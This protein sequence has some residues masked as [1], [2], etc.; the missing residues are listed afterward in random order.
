[1]GE[2]ISSVELRAAMRFALR[3][4]P[5]VPGRLDAALEG[6]FSGNNPHFRALIAGIQFSRRFIW[7]YQAV[8]VFLLICFTL[9]HWTTKLSRW[10]RSRGGS[11]R[12]R[13][14]DIPDTHSDAAATTENGTCHKGVGSSS[15]STLLGSGLSTPKAIVPVDERSPLIPDAGNTVSMVRKSWGMQTVRSWLT[16]QPRSIPI[17]NKTLPSNATSLTIL[18]LI[19]INLFY[20]L[21]GIPFQVLMLFVFAD[22]VSLVF[23]A[24]LPWLYLFAAKNQPIKRLTGYSYESLNIVHRRLG[25]IMCLL[26]LLHSVGMLGV[27]Y[28][29]LSPLGISFVQFLLSKIILLGIGALFAYEALYF[30]SLGSF[31][32]RWYELFL[33]LH[34]FLQVAALALLFFHHH[35]SRVY[36]FIA[37]VIF[38][39]DRLVYRMT[40]KTTSYRAHLCVHED[41]KTVGVT[42]EIPFTKKPSLFNR[43][44]GSNISTGWKSTDHV[45]LSIPTISRKHIVQSHPFTIASRA[46]AAEDEAAELSLTIRAQDG[47][48][49]DLLRY[50]KG[51][52]NTIVKLD[53]PYGSE[54][55]VD[56]LQNSNACIIVAGG[57]GI[58]VT[59]PLVWALLDR[60]K[61]ITSD[62]EHDSLSANQKRVLFIW[63]VQKAAHLSWLDKNFAEQ[64]ESQGVRVIVPSPTEESGRP[65]VG[66]M[67]DTWIINNDSELQHGR[68][69]TGVVCSGPD[70]LGR[71][72]RNTCA[73]LQAS[74]R[75]VSVSIEKF[76]W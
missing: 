38:L 56:M 34:I 39:I 31:R 13:G 48:S 24:N 69:R 63:V 14:L 43:I 10:R 16:Y 18:V 27:W 3:G 74:G 49:G 2:A 7:T 17:I 51:H 55:A 37:L 26:A 6:P 72:V 41:Q 30:T 19:A 75:D 4:A 58:A 42:V 64:L 52:A 23:V 9:S 46:P 8:A 35:G 29:L 59:W 15:S 1:M 12:G 20:V 57:S 76:G 60:G 40:I 28:T 70:G 11:R 68:S 21:Y 65:D 45:F 47:F 62:L 71:S 67:I 54:D 44:L 66:H 22:R 25:E 73:A 53:G 33:G 5:F 50:A 61:E 36:V 32:Q